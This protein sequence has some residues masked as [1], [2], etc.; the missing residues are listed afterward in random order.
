MIVFFLECRS[1]DCISYFDEWWIVFVGVRSVRICETHRHI[2]EHT[3]LDRADCTAIHFGA[4]LSA[5]QH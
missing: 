2:G 4:D 5:G 1:G 3:V